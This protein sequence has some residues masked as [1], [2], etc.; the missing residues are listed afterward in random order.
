MRGIK[1][2]GLGA[3][4]LAL[5]GGSLV[6]A[7]PGRQDGVK[8]PGQVQMPKAGPLSDAELGTLFRDLGYTPEEQKLPNGAIVYRMK[9]TKNN[10]TMIMDAERSPDGTKVWLSAW[11]KQLAQGEQIPQDILMKMLDVNAKNG[12]VHFSCNSNIRQLY[13]ALPMDN[14]GLTAEELRRQIDVLHT[15][16]RDSEPLWNHNKWNVNVGGGRQ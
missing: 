10:M 7:Q 9:V 13:L 8:Q 2:A 12:P 5:L 3:L 4:T 14:R 6:A 16:F 11:F 15:V 1:T